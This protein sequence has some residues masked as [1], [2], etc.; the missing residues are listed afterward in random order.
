MWPDCWALLG[1]LPANRTHQHISASLLVSLAGPFAIEVNGVWHRS[2]AALVAPDV[3]QALDP[4]GESMLVVQLDPDSSLWR[5]L[6]GRLRDQDWVE[7]EALERDWLSALSRTVAACGDSED[8]PVSPPGCTLIRRQLEGIVASVGHEPL[9]LD[10]RVARVC[11][12]LRE[13]LPE[14]LD[15]A[16]L[17]GQ[18]GLSSSRLT[19]LFRS[20][21]G[22]TLRRFLLHLKVGQA[23]AG[24]QPGM[25]FSTLASQAGFYDQPHLVRTARS[26]FDAIPSAFVATGKLR[27]VHC[28]RAEH[29]CREI[30]DSGDG[31]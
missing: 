26:M 5:R 22:V 4:L 11:R 2:R 13:T 8:G 7:L 3:P 14:R 31:H 1:D 20:S 9:P 19:H 15:V 18:V 21:T 29:S 17:A 25:S 16:A 23:L 28:P 24:W 12:L 27:L 30:S 6:C 10:P